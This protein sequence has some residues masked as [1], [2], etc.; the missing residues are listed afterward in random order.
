MFT[1][2]DVYRKPEFYWGRDPNRMCDQAVESFPAEERR[3][4]KAIDLGCGEGRDVI[5][6]ARHG[7]AA[8]GVDISRPGLEKAERWAAEEGLRIRTVQAA[9]QDFRLTE[10]FDLVYSS[11]TLTYLPPEARR[12]A[13]ENYKRYTRVGGINVFNVFVEKPFLGVPHDWGADEYFYRS[14]ELLGHYWDWEILSFSELIFDCNS[15]GVPHRHAMDV[16]IARKV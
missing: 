7:F 6:L 15:G 3:G 14:G 11:G 12:D 13:F 8:V 5:H 4:K 10:E 16:M 2:D 1:Y 9:L